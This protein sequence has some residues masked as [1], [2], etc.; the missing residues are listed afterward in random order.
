MQ[1][2]LSS[3]TIDPT[4]CTLPPSFAS[5][6]LEVA[7]APFNCSAFKPPTPGISRSITNR[8][9]DLTPYL[10]RGARNLGE[11]RKSGKT[12]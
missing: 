8:F 3:T 5:A 9:I 4:H 6:A 7:A 2:V 10:V 12:T 1:K 11:I